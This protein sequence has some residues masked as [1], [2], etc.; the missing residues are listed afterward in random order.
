ML[1][2]TDLFDICLGSEIEATPTT[3]VPYQRFF[4]LQITA[5]AHTKCSC[6]TSF[7]MPKSC[8]AT[9]RRI[10]IHST[11]TNKNDNE[12]FMSEHVFYYSLCATLDITMHHN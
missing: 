7:V 12:M 10:G 9:L 2:C 3:T 6:G 5:A 11:F 1:L 4:F 8:G